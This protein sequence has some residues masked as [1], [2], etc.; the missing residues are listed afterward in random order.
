MRKAMLELV[1]CF[2]RLRMFELTH[3]ISDFQ[4]GKKDAYA[5]QEAIITATKVLLTQGAVEVN[6]GQIGLRSLQ[7]DTLSSKTNE[8]LSDPINSE[9]VQK[10]IRDIRQ[11]GI[12]QNKIGIFSAHQMGSCRMGSSPN[13]SAV[14]PQGETWDVKGLYVADASVFPTASGVNPMITTYSVAYSIA[15]F[16]KK[17]LA[18]DVSE[19]LTAKL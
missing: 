6:T 10:F 1:E 11:F 7:L 13:N 2:N 16:M 18:S 5:L 14:N 17:G 19:S 8:Y 4:I 15:Q 12:V 9:P 3:L